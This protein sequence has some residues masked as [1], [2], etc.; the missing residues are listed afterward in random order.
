MKTSA[1]LAK[2]TQEAI[3]R[4][5]KRTLRSKKAARDFLIG[6]GILTK[7]GKQLAKPYR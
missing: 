2:E 7:S 3:K 6:A 1:E 4:V 5:S